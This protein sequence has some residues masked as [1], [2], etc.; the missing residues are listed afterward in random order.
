M[1][2][3]ST[4]IKED[5]NMRTM[6]IMDNVDNSS[7]TN[8]DATFCIYIVFLSERSNMHI[9]CFSNYEI[10]SGGHFCSKRIKK[11]IENHVQMTH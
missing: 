9:P 6:D 7:L 2:I 5:E 4:H 11:K 8:I 1:Q 3:L 10:S